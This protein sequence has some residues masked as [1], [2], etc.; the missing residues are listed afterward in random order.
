MNR[1]SQNR[2]FLLIWLALFVLLGFNVWS[3]QAGHLMV[4]LFLFATVPGYGIYACSARCRM[5]GFRL[6]VRPFRLFGM[7]LFTWS[8]LM[9]A[10]CRQCGQPVD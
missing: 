6:L 3:F 1:R 8:L 5:C 4:I 10:A 7:S 2:L 9:P